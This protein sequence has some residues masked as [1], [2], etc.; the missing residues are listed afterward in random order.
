MNEHQTNIE[1]SDL[2]GSES[3]PNPK[4]MNM[5]LCTKYVS[6]A[7][8]S[9]WSKSLKKFRFCGQF[10]AHPIGDLYLIFNFNRFW[11]DLWSAMRYMYIINRKYQ[12]DSGMYIEINMLRNVNDRLTQPAYNL[13]IFWRYI[14]IW[15]RTIVADISLINFFIK[16]QRKNSNKKIDAKWK[17]KSKQTVRNGNEWKNQFT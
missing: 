13:H 10:P 7:V 16:Y 12:V 8:R 15:L 3:I 2:C 4:P 14:F 5:I 6:S 9:D 1:C 17:V 11:F